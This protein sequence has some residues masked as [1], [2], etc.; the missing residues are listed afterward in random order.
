M[1]NYPNDPRNLILIVPHHGGAAGTIDKSQNS[2]FSRAII[3]VGANN[4]YNHP[5]NTVLDSFQNIN[6]VDCTSNT[7]QDILIVL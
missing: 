3:S 5:T 7:K 2:K 4:S 1:K 6:I